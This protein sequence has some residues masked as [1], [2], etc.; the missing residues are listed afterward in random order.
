MDGWT[1]DGG[2]K[3]RQKVTHTFD[4]Y[5]SYDSNLLYNHSRSCYLAKTQQGPPYSL[6][7]VQAQPGPGP[8][9]NPP[10]DIPMT[11]GS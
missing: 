2:I 4:I 7:S 9:F 6:D 5:D 11:A 1:G 8:Q 3:S 10:H